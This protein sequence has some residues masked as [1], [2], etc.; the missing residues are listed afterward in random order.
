[1]ADTFDPAHLIG[2]VK[3]AAYFEVPR[4]LDRDG[5]VDGRV[6]IPQPFEL[7]HPV[8]FGGPFEPLDLRITKFMILEVVGAV[9][10][11]VIFI[12][13][14]VSFCCLASLSILLRITSMS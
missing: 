6:L 14:A 10:V 5:T 12:R 8:Q 11:A 2:H 7:A 4:V 9:L 13:L 1:M 3:D